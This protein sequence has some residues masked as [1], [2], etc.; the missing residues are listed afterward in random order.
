MFKM[1]YLINKM[2][3]NTLSQQ[4]WWLEIGV[5]TSILEIVGSNLTNGVFVVNGGK[6]TKNFLT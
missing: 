3:C 1:K 4:M 2:Q 5:F 6:L